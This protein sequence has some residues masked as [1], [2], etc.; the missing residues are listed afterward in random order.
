MVKKDSPE[1]PA[2][3]R[4]AAISG[5]TNNDHQLEIDEAGSDKRILEIYNG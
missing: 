2:D 4:G 5:E 3:Y 1:D